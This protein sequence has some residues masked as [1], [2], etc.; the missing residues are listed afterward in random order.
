GLPEL[1]IHPHRGQSYSE[2]ASEAGERSDQPHTFP[3]GSWHGL[4]VC[5]LT[6]KAAKCVGA[7]RGE[8]DETSDA[9]QVSAL[10]AADLCRSYL[11]EPAAGASHRSSAGEKE[12]L[13]RP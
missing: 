13:R 3:Y 11:D 10:H 4:Q 5:A 7:G 8:R 1:S 12:H 2:A 6:P 9:D